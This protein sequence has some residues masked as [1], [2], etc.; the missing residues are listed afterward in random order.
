MTSSCPNCKREWEHPPLLEGRW[1]GPCEVCGVGLC[2]PCRHILELPIGDFE[3]CLKC[4]VVAKGK[5]NGA[6]IAALERLRKQRTWLRVG[7][8]SREY[9]HGTANERRTG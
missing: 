2:K 9:G 7:R 8:K 1:L 3:V 5:I 6:I 4:E